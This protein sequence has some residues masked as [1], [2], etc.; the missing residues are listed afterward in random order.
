MTTINFWPCTKLSYP[1]G[2]TVHILY[3]ATVHENIPFFSQDRS[4]HLTNLLYHVLRVSVIAAK[5]T[6]I[7]DILYDSLFSANQGKPLHLSFYLDTWQDTK[8]PFVIMTCLNMPADKT[9]TQTIFAVQFTFRSF[10]TWE[11]PLDALSGITS[12]Y[13][14]PTS[15]WL[16]VSSHYRY[17]PMN[18]FDFFSKDSS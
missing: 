3:F 1:W 4:W 7:S 9:I 6:D 11:R 17:N 10:L 8:N 13:S 16:T 5:N 14:S 2:T 12:R 15:S 18:D